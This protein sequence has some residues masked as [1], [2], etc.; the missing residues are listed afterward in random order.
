MINYKEQF[1]KIS[2]HLFDGDYNSVIS[3]SA[4]VMEQGLKKLYKDQLAYFETEE[5]A[6]CIERESLESITKDKFPNFDINMATLGYIIKFYHVTRFFDLLQN[7]LDVRLT[8][9][10]KLPWTKIVNVR[11]SIT[12]DDFIAKKEVAID[13]IHYTKVFIYETGLDD[14]YNEKH[15]FNKCHECSS[16]VDVDWNYCANCGADLAEKCKK[17][18]EP[19]KQSWSICPS[20]KTPRGGVKLKDP[21]TMYK[22]YCEAVWVDG[23]LTKEE[24]NFLDRKRE[25]LGLSIDK[26]HEIEKIFTPMEA[27]LFREAV[28]AT[29]VD[30][31]IDDDERDYLRRRAYELGVSEK[32]A[33]EIFNACLTIDSLENLFAKNESKLIVMKNT[34]VKLN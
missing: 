3:K 29:L 19:L 22:H 21:V 34:N 31:V 25:E 4:W 18:G 15:K 10:R 33:N 13:F 5:S 32:M 27:I 24:K 12:H 17:C 7:R 20:C 16:I 30:R 2:H 28:E 9:T 14:R 11:N 26:A 6:S 23:V 1:Q 8:F